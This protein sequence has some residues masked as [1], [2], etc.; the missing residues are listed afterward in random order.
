MLRNR[1][2]NGPLPSALCQA[3]HL[4]MVGINNHQMEGAIPSFTGTLSLLALHRNRLK[5]LPDLH[6]E[7]NASTTAVL[8]H[9]NELSC[10]VPRCGDVSVSTSIVAIGNRLRHPK[11]K[12]PAWVSKYERDPLFWVSGF[13]GISLLLKI[14]GAVSFFAS[15][16]AWK[17]DKRRWLRAISEWQ[18]G[19]VAHIWLV[20]IS[21]H[22]CSCLMKESL[23]AV[24]FLML[25]LFWDVYACPEAL[26]MASACLRS[27]AL[28]RVLVFLCWCQ[29]A[30]HSLA[31]EH[32]I[33]ECKNQKEQWT[34]KMLTKRLFSWLLWC[35]WQ[36]CFQAS[37]DSIR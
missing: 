19:P 2:L 6:L 31:V 11:G 22:L 24:V 7:D 34:E 14:T 26:A 1:G 23:L 15:V 10:Y 27:S 9:D 30:F 13:E 29:L 21:S 5:I 16:M 25:L 32:L 3:S 12:F 37:L 8:L 20:Q 35:F 33:M 18:I 4:K 28:L 36:W 17:L